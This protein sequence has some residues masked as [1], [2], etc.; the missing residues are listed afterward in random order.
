VRDPLFILRLGPAPDMRNI[1]GA[2][3]GRWVA[4]NL[5]PGRPAPGGRWTRHPSLPFG[6]KAARPTACRWY[7][8]GVLFPSLPK[9]TF[10]P[11]GQFP[12][13]GGNGAEEDTQVSRRPPPQ[14]PRRHTAPNPTLPGGGA[15]R[16]GQFLHLILAMV[17]GQVAADGAGEVPIC[18]T[19][20]AVLPARG[21]PA[22]LPPW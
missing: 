17:G 8:I 6:G 3:G 19:A 13:G 11:S 22:P 7:P 21:P 15:Q 20:L 1:A 4:S 14:S 2:E 18:G 16:F 12:R 9:L 10:R 5:P